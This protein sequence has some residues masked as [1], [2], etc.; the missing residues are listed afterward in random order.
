MDA[1]TISVLLVACMFACMLERASGSQEE[2]SKEYHVYDDCLHVKNEMST[3]QINKFI[4]EHGRDLFNRMVLGLLDT[5][6]ECCREKRNSSSIFDERNCY[7]VVPLSD[8]EKQQVID[9][10]A[11]SSAA[12]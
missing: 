10:S 3:E 8:H 12:A 5:C 1:K 4:Q 11:A 2:L 9:R 7:C 6:S